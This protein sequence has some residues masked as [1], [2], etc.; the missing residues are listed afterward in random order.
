VIESKRA[1]SKASVDYR[2]PIMSVS[3]G[4][5]G[6]L[7]PPSGKFFPLDLQIGVR[8]AVVIMKVSGRFVMS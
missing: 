8:E 1:W 7:A 4:T 5:E 3:A 2:Y 6:K